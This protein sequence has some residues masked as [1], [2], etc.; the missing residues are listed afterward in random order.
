MNTIILAALLTSMAFAVVVPPSKYWIF[1]EDCFDGLIAL[2]QCI[3]FTVFKGLGFGI[4]AGSCL[5]KL[6]QIGKMMA[7][8]SADGVPAIS[9]YAEFINL[10]GLLGNSLRL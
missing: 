3:M 2:D 9:L 10:I 6:P 1:R 5:F 4:V 7:A 8:K